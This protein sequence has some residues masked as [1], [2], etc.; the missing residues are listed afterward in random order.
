M[1]SP[2]HIAEL[3]LREAVE[4]TDY[5]RFR[6]EHF[7]RRLGWPV[8]NDDGED[9]HGVDIGSHHIVAYADTGEVVGCIRLTPPDCPGW[10][11]D[12]PPFSSA[13]PADHAPGFPRH[14]ALEISRLGVDT[15]FALL[16]T[17]AGYTVGQALRRGAYQASLRL[18]YRYWYVVA[19]QK[20]LRRL[21][22]DH[23][24]F[25]IIGA[26]GGADQ[27]VAVAW[28]DLASAYVL[29][30]DRDRDF[31]HWNNAGLG[32]DR[33]AVLMEPT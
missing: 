9:R 11:I 3:D 23:L 28:L 29:M 22:R 1:P 32:L 19:Y 31:L 15:R 4:T 24:P 7:G 12:T 8:L 13:I 30:A 18:G 21:R 26:W 17:E 16:R 27:P 10:M 33:L 25:R 6:T 5:F 14:E 20:L 2:I